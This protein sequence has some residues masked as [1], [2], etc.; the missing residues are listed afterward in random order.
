MTVVALPPEVDIMTEAGPSMSLRAAAG[1]TERQ[2]SVRA[3]LEL[4]PAEYDVVICHDVARPFAEPALFD[5]VLDAL[6]RP[7]GGRAAD[8]AVPVVPGPDTLKRV[9]DGVVLETLD[10]TKVLAAQTPQAFRR[11]A[12]EEAHRLARDQG[13]TGTDDAALLERAGF[14]VAAVE[15]DARNFKVTVPED[16]ARAEGVVRDG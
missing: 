2:D 5:T 4:V 6:D 8:G 3:A 9:D 10:R 16:L 7:I 1:G 11:Q 14:R 13:F 15:G 12:L